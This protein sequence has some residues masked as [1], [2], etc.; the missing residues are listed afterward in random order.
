MS[1]ST[2][3]QYQINI[4]GTPMSG[5]HV[6]CTSFVVWDVLANVNYCTKPASYQQNRNSD[7]WLPRV[8]HIIRGLEYLANI[9]HVTTSVS[10]HVSKPTSTGEHN[11]H[12][13]SIRPHMYPTCIKRCSRAS[14]NMSP[15]GFS[16]YQTMITCQYQTPKDIIRSTDQQ[17][18][19]DT[20]IFTC[21]LHGVPVVLK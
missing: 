4:T 7:I 1:T 9:K 15:H 10:R 19:C 21:L 13:R 17:S 11:A 18:P 5:C 16:K 12:D 20:P 14:A 6:C 2:R 8:M 3:S